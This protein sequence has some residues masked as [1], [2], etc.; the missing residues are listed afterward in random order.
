MFAFGA[1]IIGGLGS[2]L[3]FLVVLAV[4]PPGLFGHPR[5]AG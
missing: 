1:V 5:A 4:R 3:L 2:Q